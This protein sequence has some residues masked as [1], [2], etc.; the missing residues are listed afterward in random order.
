MNI[1]TIGFS[2]PSCTLI[3]LF[4][5]FSIFFAFTGLQRVY[6]VQLF[7]KNEKPFGISYDDWV[8]KY[9]NWDLGL[10]THQFAPK[11]G[12]CV[13]NNSSSI[14]MLLETEIDGSRHMTCN[15]SS[16]QGI[17]IPLWIGWCD[18]G[19]DLSRIRNPNY[20]LDQKLSECAREVYN[21]GN[22]RAQVKVDSV[23]VANLN[24]RLSS[25]SGSLDYK[26]NSLTNVTELFTKGFNLTIPPNTHK[27]YQVPGTWRAGS[28][29]W[30]V[31]LKPLPPGKHTV[32][33]SVHFTP[34]GPVTTPSTSTHFADITY[35]LQV[36]K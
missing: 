21:L 7:S 34:T 32:F 36:V 18:T 27:V 26:I 24:V 17:M 30:W 9:W 10:N 2:R 35:N 14:V 5:L 23:P 16:K 29:G 25:T 15:V 11:Q 20:N 28:Q 1:C 31:F 22:I 19:G 13:I 4:L 3:T 12:G 6:A 8:A 33:Y